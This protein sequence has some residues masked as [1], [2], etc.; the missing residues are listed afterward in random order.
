MTSREMDRD[1]GR[2][3]R[4]DE[5]DGARGEP[6]EAIE[7]LRGVWTATGQSGAEMEELFGP[8]KSCKNMQNV[9]FDDFA[10]SDGDLREAWRATLEREGKLSERPGS[11]RDLVLGPAVRAEQ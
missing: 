8:A 5:R 9:G 3:V 7:V 4:Q 2:E 10:G 6:D 1:P 11:V